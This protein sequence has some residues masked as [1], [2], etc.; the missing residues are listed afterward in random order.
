MEEKNSEITK[1]VIRFDIIN[2]IITYA[3]YMEFI[4][5]IIMKR[6]KGDL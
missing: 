6:L 2:Y 1:K 4:V 3:N 5:S